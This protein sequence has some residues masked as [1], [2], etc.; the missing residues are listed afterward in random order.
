VSKKKLQGSRWCLV[1]P[2]ALPFPAGGLRPMNDDTQ[3][4]QRPWPVAVRSGPT[5]ASHRAQAW[6]QGGTNTLTKDQ[7]DL[8]EQLAKYACKELQR[9]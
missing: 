6:K 9:S 3:T 1:E 8:H 7:K 2:V 5:D 4:P